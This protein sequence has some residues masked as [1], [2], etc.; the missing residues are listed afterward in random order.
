MDFF[1]SL[2]APLVDFVNRF[3]NPFADLFATVPEEPLRT[4]DANNPAA[5]MNPTV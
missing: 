5:Q 1:T 2:Q 3:V 4:L